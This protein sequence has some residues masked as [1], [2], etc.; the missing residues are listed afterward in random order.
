MEV[1]VKGY[2]FTEE[3]RGTAKT[4]IFDIEEIMNHDN[5]HM[6]YH[7]M[8]SSGTLR[9]AGYQYGMQQF[10]EKYCIQYTDGQLS[11]IFAL[12]K[13]HAMNFHGHTDAAINFIVKIEQE[14]YVS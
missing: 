4:S 11:F 2:G 7:N 13:K 10:L 9:L 5:Y 6:S 1:K 12:N 3:T 14:H 8:I